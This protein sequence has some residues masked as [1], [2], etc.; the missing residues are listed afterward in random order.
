MTPSNSPSETE[1][2]LSSQ[3]A[4]VMTFCKLSA[5][6]QSGCDCLKQP[7][8]KEIDKT[9]YVRRIKLTTVA[10]TDFASKY[11]QKKPY[12]G[13]GC[14]DECSYR[15]VSIYSIDDSTE[16]LMKREM[17]DNV[18]N[19]PKLPRVFCRFKMKDGAGRV[20]SNGHG[21]GINPYHHD[22]LKSDQ[23]CL[24]HVEVVELAELDVNTKQWVNVPATKAE[25]QQEELLHTPG[26][27]LEKE[28]QVSVQNGSQPQQED[29]VAQHKA[30]DQTEPSPQT[31]DGVVESG[32]KESSVRL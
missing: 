1:Q 12:H 18:I 13:K 5:G 8:V 21:S 22:L 23:F 2:S 26:P 7:G 32:N 28:I 10:E 16:S 15:G 29:V 31:K 11:E 9:H 27:P 3:T 30:D 25:I 14:A 24:E 6:L 19:K 4:P 20:W 17:G